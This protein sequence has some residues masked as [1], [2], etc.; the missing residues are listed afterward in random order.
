[1]TV[2]IMKITNVSL[3]L[4]AVRPRSSILEQKEGHLQTLARKVCAACSV[5]AGAA[6]SNHLMMTERLP[7]PTVGS[8]KQSEHADRAVYTAE[9]RHEVEDTVEL[10]VLGSIC[11]LD[12]K[13]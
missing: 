5:T 4:M 6:H 13:G 11:L 7:H 10:E 1:M 2:S 8:E 12:T 3:W 9:E